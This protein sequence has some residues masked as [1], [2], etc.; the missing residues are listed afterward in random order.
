MMAFRT[1]GPRDAETAFIGE[2]SSTGVD[3]EQT[4]MRILV[5]LIVQQSFCSHEQAVRLRCDLA[6]TSGCQPNGHHGEVINAGCKV[7]AYAPAAI[8]KACMRRRARLA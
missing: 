5:I 2:H 4:R 7:L 8:P 1:S 3:K 6:P